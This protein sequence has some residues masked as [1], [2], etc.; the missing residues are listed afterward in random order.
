M[1]PQDAAKKAAA[2][3]ACAHVED[4]HVVGLGT[5]STADFA[6]RHL[7]ERVKAGLRIR[8]VPTS[9]RSAELARSLGIPLAD[10]GDVA[11]IDVTIDGADEVDP[12]LDLI[13]GLGGALLR[14]KIV[15]SLT[16]T[17]IIVVDPSKMVP[18]LGTRSPLPVEVIPFGAKVVERRLAR[19]GYAPTLRAKDGKPVVTD[20]GNLVLDLRFER[21]IDDPA[22]LEPWLNNLPGVV[23]NGLFLGMTARVVIGEADGKIREI[24]RP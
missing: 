7:G 17:Q 2:E 18:R 16:R 19:E 23:D 5:G 24:A 13:K 21:G 9:V 4:G 20:N 10:P 8:G 1:Q 6:I 11:S 14:E 15:A 3:A 12:R 22:R